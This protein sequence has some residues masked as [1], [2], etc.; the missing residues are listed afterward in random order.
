MKTIGIIAE[1]NP[2]HNGH[3]YLIEKSMQKTG[4]D[5]CVVIMSG[6][7]VQRGAPA[8][9]DKF[10]RAK[11]ALHS[12]ADLVIELPIYY[13]LGSAEY[14]ASG[15]V[16]ILDRLGTIDYLCFGSESGDIASLT[17]IA[18]ILANEPGNFKAVL[19]NELKKGKSFAAAREEALVSELGE[20]GIRSVLQSPNNILAL[21]YIKALIKRKSNIRPFT[22]ARRGEAFHSD[23]LSDYA[24]ATAIRRALSENTAL[25]ALSYSVP[26]KSLK[27]LIEYRGRLLDSDDFSL[28][29][30]YR[31]ISE[32]GSACDRYLDVSR[33]F[34]NKL[35]STFTPGDTITELCEKL[36]TKDLSYSR[37]S[38]SLFHILLGITAENM[39]LYKADDYTGYVRVL[40]LKKAS[41]EVLSLIH[42]NASIPILD[43]LKDADR[44]LDPLQLM[45]FNESL[46]AGAVYNLIAQNGITSEYSLRNIVI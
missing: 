24:S 12:G 4:A 45:L 15:A 30:N 11:M 5:F 14:F 38:R 44:L 23:T 26:E 1:F 36:K 6:D 20:E 9:A 35:I 42:D 37:I 33:D 41:S 10:T 28:L 43:R 2:F 40:G 19:A 31:L 21:E 29:L 27:Q 7:F 32:K 18:T 34:S 46:S 8:I 13:S 16:S 3:K 17:D 22:I 39:A 25:E